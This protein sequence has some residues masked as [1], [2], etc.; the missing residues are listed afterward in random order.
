MRH[1]PSAARLGGTDPGTIVREAALLLDDAQDYAKRAVPVFPYG[2]GKAAIRI[3][4]AIEAFQA[5][6]R[7][8]APARY[9]SGEAVDRAGACA[10]KGAR[11]R[12]ADVLIS[13]KTAF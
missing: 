12:C 4:D 6:R 7:L 5:R 9:P 3:A 1:R 11:W 2:D 13:L 10:S 8:P